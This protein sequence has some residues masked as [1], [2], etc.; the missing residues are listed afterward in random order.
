MT[1]WTQKILDPIITLFLTYHSSISKIRGNLI[2]F[3]SQKPRNFPQIKLH[4]QPFIYFHNIFSQPPPRNLRP[5]VSHR[6]NIH[7]IFQSQPLDPSTPSINY[8]TPHNLL[9]HFTAV[10]APFILSLQICKFLQIYATTVVFPPCFL[11]FLIDRST[12]Y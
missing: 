7:P 9:S 5:C 12:I 6:K 1:N 3:S 4:H 2:L 10:S 11:K 8:V